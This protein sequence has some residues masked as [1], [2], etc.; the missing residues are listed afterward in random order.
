MAVSYTY[1]Y[2]YQIKPQQKYLV[3]Q[4]VELASNIQYTIY[5]KIFRGNFHGFHSSSLN[6]KSYPMNQGLVT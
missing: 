2:F 1:N 6:P 3:L 5:G 4:K